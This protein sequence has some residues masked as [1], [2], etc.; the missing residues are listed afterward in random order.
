MQSTA[1]TFNFHVHHLKGFD[2]W[3]FTSKSFVSIVVDLNDESR[4]LV[5]A[6][7]SGDIQELFP[8]AEVREGE[9]TDYKFRAS[10]PAEE[11][12]DCLKEYVM[13]MKYGNFK[14][15]VPDDQE[16]RKKAYFSVWSTMH[17]FQ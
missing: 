16:Q 3:L 12:A 9:G 8:N 6:R 13:A 4:R 2:M 1:K 15:S 11:V 10:I 5:R 7:F 14:D 17:G